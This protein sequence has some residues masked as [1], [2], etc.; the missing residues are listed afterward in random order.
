MAAELARVRGKFVSKVSTAVIKQ[1]LDDLLDDDVLNDGQKDSILEEN[2]TTADKARSLVDI[3]KKKGDVASRKMIA[4]LYERDPTLHSEVGLSRGQPAQPAAEQQMKQDWSTTLIPTTDSFWTEKKNDRKTYS[5]EKNS[6]RNRVALL[7]T[8]IKFTD[9]RHNRNGAEKDEENMEKLLRALGYKVVKYT[10][11]TGKAIDDAVMKFSKLPELKETDSVVVVI[12]SHGKL[13]AVLGCNWTKDD[14]E[15]PDEFPIDNIY[16]HLGSEKCPAL[17][18]K[19]KII[20]I[21]ACRGAEK[22]SVL[23]SDDAVVCDDVSQPG[24]PPCAD[25][26]NIED[27]NLK[28]VHKEKDFISLLSSTPDTVSYR[29]RNNGSFLIQYIVDVF[30]TLAHKEHIDELF[31]EVM[32]RFEEFSVQSLRQMP[33]KDRTTLTKH[34]YFFPGL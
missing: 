6:I 8:N 5:A 19:P 28:C 2:N 21:Q 10:N 1:L 34:F 29:Q 7:I 26:E 16:K 27:D 20:I 15:K 30:N 12:M 14:V 17:L 4:H 23:V 22:G 32:Q 25:E 33:T 24:P 9:E 11:L 31:R 3:I 18:N 13:G